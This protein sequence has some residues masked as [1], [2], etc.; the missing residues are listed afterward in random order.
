MKRR[1]R[2]LLGV[3]III[4]VVAPV[5]AFT[6][7]TAMASPGGR[8]PSWPTNYTCS[9]GNL[10]TGT[11]SVIPSGTYGNLTVTG[12]CQPAPNAVINVIG[13]VNVSAHGALDAQSYPSK[14]TVGRDVTAG[15]GALLGL[16]C[17]PN[18]TATST[19]GH[20]CVDA[21]GKP[22]TGQSEITVNGNIIAWD[23]DTVLLNGI[24]VR[25]SVALLGGGGAIPWAIKTNTIGGN[26]LVGNVTPDW[27]G[28]IVNKVGGNVLLVNV[29]ITDTDPNPAIFVASNTIGQNL[30]CFGLAPAVSGGFGNEHNVVGGHAFGQCAN[31][32][33]E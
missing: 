3:A 24:T 19:T 22:T 27:L 23:A 17:L 32:L 11:F 6:G 2:I 5:G 20:P 29:H 26:L 1:T 4:G 10:Q 30:A 21:H 12:A 15:P 9:G 25:G 7:G 28:V 14:L 31:L 33:D 18:P 13:N 8:W 16:G